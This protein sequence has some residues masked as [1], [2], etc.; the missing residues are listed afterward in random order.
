MR[1]QAEKT[2]N[3]LS[4]EVMLENDSHNLLWHHSVQTDH[5]I[6]EQRADLFQQIR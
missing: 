3:Y 5:V 4:S 2:V 6:E 1:E